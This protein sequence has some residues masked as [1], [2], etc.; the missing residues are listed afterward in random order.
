VAFVVLNERGEAVTV[1]LAQGKFTVYTDETGQRL[2]FNPFLGAPPSPPNTT[3]PAPPKR[4]LLSLEELK[5]QT[6]GA[7]Q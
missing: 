3:A 6:Q 7:A 1:S 5:R 4:S 2:V